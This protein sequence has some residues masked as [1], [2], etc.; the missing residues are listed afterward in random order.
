MALGFERFPLGTGGIERGVV[1]TIKHQHT[2]DVTIKRGGRGAVDEKQNL[3]GVGVFVQSG[4]VDGLRVGGAVVLR[5]VGEEGGGLVCPEL[6]TEFVKTG[7]FS[8]FD[9]GTPVAF[10]R[11]FQQLREDLLKGRV[12]HVVEEDFGQVRVLFPASSYAGRART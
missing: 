3:R 8:D 5:A 2:T 9:H 11:G 12:L 7:G 10:E 6:S 4:E 1:A